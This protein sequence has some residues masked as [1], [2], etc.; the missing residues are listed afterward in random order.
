LTVTHRLTVPPERAGERLDRYL[1]GTLPGLSRARIQQLISEGFVSLRDGEARPSA[2]L[3]GREEITVSIPP[4]RPVDLVPENRP[5]A[6]LFE[7]DHLMVVEKQAGM[8]VHPSPGHSAGTLVHA[9]LSRAG[10]LSGIG[11]AFRPGIVHR[12]DRDTSGI[13]V[14]AKDDL[15]HTGLSSQLAAHRMDRRYR[16][17]VWGRPPGAEGEIRTR[18][19]R[20]PV[21]RKKMAVFP[22]GRSRILRN[23]TAA[24]PGDASHGRKG[25]RRIAIT[26][27]RCLESFGNFSLLEF[28][29]T[30]GRTHQIRLH[31]A[32]IS[33]PI[34]GD[35]VYG[36]PRKVVLGR[37]K[38]AASVTVFRFLLHAFHLGF[39]HPRTGQSLAFTVPDPPEFG[40]FR[41]EV[42]AADR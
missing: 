1:S 6:V 13:I 42:M 5:V 40:E 3:K 17:I 38:R 18:V 22:V 27:Y 26:R 11:G 12:L 41:S 14:V 7:D 10:S 20:H 31:C 2:R 33:C 28:R 34:V 15:S 36:R 30:T 21:H 23:G 16:G 4:S 9:L 35:D 39:V 19:G 32:H 29:L 25:G 8:V 37:G 24:A